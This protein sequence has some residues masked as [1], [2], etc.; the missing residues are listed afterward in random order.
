MQTWEFLTT[1]YPTEG[2]KNSVQYDRRFAYGDPTLP[3]DALLYY[4]HQGELAGIL[5][6][7]PQDIPTPQR[8]PEGKPMEEKGNVTIW[9]RPDLEFRVIAMPLAKESV[10]RWDDMDPVKEW[11]HYFPHCQAFVQEWRNTYP[12]W[13]IGATF[14]PDAAE[15]A[16]AKADPPA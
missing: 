5:E 11:N 14:D 10:K 1:C 16:R 12:E 15:A 7:Y 2:Q 8:P 4:D 3:I 13:E 6:H 9:N